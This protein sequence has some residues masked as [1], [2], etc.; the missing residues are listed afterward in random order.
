MEELV[1]RI[2]QNLADRVG[3]PLTFRFLL[4]PLMAVIFAAVD[5]KR[6][7]AAGAPPYFWALFTNPDH[8]RE[9]LQDGWKSIGK[10][11]VL[12]LCLDVV[13]QLI[14]LRWIYVAEAL[15]VAVLLAIVPYVL[16]RGPFNRI[17]RGRKGLQ[18]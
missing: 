18:P 16:L 4:Q 9:M 14:V 8:R 15:I 13:Y 11:F 17:L 5:G 10:V 12:A 2:A 1:A 6:D 3:G 7:A